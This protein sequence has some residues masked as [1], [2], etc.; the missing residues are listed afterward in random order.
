MPHKIFASFFYLLYFIY[1]QSLAANNLTTKTA[2]DHYQSLAIDKK[3]DQ[4]DTWLR[5]LHYPLGKNKSDIITKSFFISENGAINAKLELLE[6]IKVLLSNNALTND[7]VCKY[8]ARKLWLQQQLNIPN[9]LFSKKKC[10]EL[11]AWLS[12][13][14]SISL[15]FADGYLKNPASLYGHLLLKFNNADKKSHLLDKS[16]N[17]GANIPDDENSLIYIFNGITGGYPAKFS[18]AE[19]YKNTHI[20]KELEQ[21]NLW[22]YQLNLTKQQIQLIE[23]H[24][25][26][27]MI[28]AQFDYYF[29]KQ[30]CAYRLAELI[31]LVT[32]QTIINQNLPWTMPTDTLNRLHD[33][34]NLISSINYYPSRETL[35]LERYK[36]LEIHLQPIVNNFIETENTSLL[37]LNELTTKNKTDI[38]DTLFNYYAFIHAENLEDKK[39]TKIKK[40]LL[41]AQLKL[42][43][44]PLT[45]ITHKTSPPHSGQKP[46]LT[47]LLLA[48]NKKLKTGT[49]LRIRPAYYDHLSIDTGR[50]PH[51]NLTMLDLKLGYFNQ[52]LKLYSLDIVNIETL[53]PYKKHIPNQHPY[54]WKFRFGAEPKFNNC[55]PCTTYFTEAGIG[56]SYMN[57]IGLFFAMMEGRAE[58]GGDSHFSITPRIGSIFNPSTNWKSIFEIGNKHYLSTNVKNTTIIKWSN[59]F[60]HFRNWDI[61]FTITS[62]R[63]TEATF[64]FSLYW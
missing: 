62:A 57:N 8:P 1:S 12:D 4:S 52:Q 47:Q 38:Y 36:S 31:E 17:F 45:A 13:A 25:W 60:G 34:Q 26:E 30:N 54:A 50:L 7:A 23:N 10:V 44:E 46:A 56:K 33:S 15:I 11:N 39:Y 2:V 9:A 59:R 53:N 35:F 43:F 49:I 40:I 14:S 16:I 64:A 37:H 55:F 21:R 24:I 28:N 20:Y 5:L 63:T 27:L 22:E 51:S 41:Q 19:F 58:S 29:L 42:P 18:S 3:L 32:D 6:T 61:Q 48:N